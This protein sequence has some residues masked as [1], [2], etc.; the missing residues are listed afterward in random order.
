MRR[1]T[2]LASLP[3]AGGG[4]P[5]ARPVRPARPLR[6]AAREAGPALWPPGEDRFIRGDVHAGDRP[7]GASFASR[8]AVY[9]LSGAAG[10]AH[11]L[12][13]LAGD[14]DV[15]ARRLGGRCGDRD[16]R[17]PGLPR[18]DLLRH[19]R[20]LL[21][22]A[23][24]SGAAQ[25]RR[26]GRLG[27][28]PARAHPRDRPRARG[29]GGALPPARRGRGVGAGRGRRLV[30]A[31]P[32]LRPAALGRAVSARDRA[33][34]ARARRCPTSS[35]IISASTSR[36]SADAG[37][38]IEEIDN[39][40][41]TWAP[42]GH[43][44]AA[45]GDVPQSRS[46]PHLPD[47]RRGRPRR[48]L[49][50]RD[51]RTIDAYF[52]RIGGWLRRRGPRRPSQRMG[53]AATRPIIAASTSMRLAP[54][55][56]GHRDPADAQHDREVR[57]ARLWASSRRSR[58]TIAVE[59]K[60]LAYED[61]ARYYADPHFASV[62]VEW[63]ISKDYARRARRADPARPGHP[64]S[65]HP[66]EAPSHGDTTYFSVADEDGMMVSMIQSNFRGMGSGLVADG[67]GFMFQDRG[68]L[69]SLQRRPSQ[70]LC[71]GQAAVPD[72]HPRLRDARRRAVAGAS[73]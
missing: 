55:T 61:R 12:A 41:R 11:P 52:R 51:R 21:R 7:V 18:A 73:G 34:R 30:D 23:L 58:S 65:G 69:F 62:P 43:A 48:L 17:L 24:G 32:A 8:S 1:R 70:H 71:A 9:G 45:G 36:P 68:E 15:E 72:H 53:R 42:D 28:S 44:P 64:R 14:R 33:R 26:P 16:E 2:F 57:H 35:P 60:R 19:R 22:D 50:G 49:R 39:A 59:A 20:R 3:L 37:A 38:A 63:L 31:A 54:N 47:D 40:M 10:T 6:A 67:L 13:T 66:G 27:R 5:A 4:R 56:P 29:Q 46:R 25:G